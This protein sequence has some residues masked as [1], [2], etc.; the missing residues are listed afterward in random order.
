MKKLLIAILA[1]L[2]L[3]AGCQE[4][5]KSD[6]ERFKEEYGVEG[7]MVSYM[8]TDDVVYQLSH[9]THAVLISDNKTG[10]DQAVALAASSKAYSGMMIFYLN[11]K[12]LSDNLKKDII[13]EIGTYTGVGEISSPAVFFVKDGA[14]LNCYIGGGTD[15]LEKLYS[16]SFEQMVSEHN[17]GCD[18][19]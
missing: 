9:G 13:A 2:L 10:K 12:D 16:E 7:P 3:L 8:K 6:S 1:V 11:S 15:G 4:K 19:C 18:D 17:P 5:K 14:I